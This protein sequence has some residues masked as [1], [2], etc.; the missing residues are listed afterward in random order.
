MHSSGNVIE[1]RGKW[2][3]RVQVAPGKREAFVMPWATERAEAAD[4]A[5][6]LL[7]VSA[8]IRATKNA[9]T[10][11]ILPKLLERAA[12]ATDAARL[13]DVRKVVDGLVAGSDRVE[14]R[15]TTIGHTFGDVAKAWTSGELAAKYPD[16]VKKKRSADDDAQRL[17]AHVLPTI[18]AVSMRS[19]TLDHA[20]RVMESLDAELAPATRRQVAQVMH[21][22]ASLAVYPLRLLAAH[23]LP[24]GWLPKIPKGAQ[25][26]QEMPKPSEVDQFVACKTEPIGVRL[27]AGFLA[28]EGL[29]HEEAEGLTW[30][31]VDLEDGIVRLDENKTNVP[32][33]WAL[34]ADVARALRFWFTARGSPKRSTRVF[35]D[36]KGDK[37]SLRADE[38]REALARARVTRAELHKGSKVTK[39][40]GLHALR[41]LFVSE[42]FA[43]GE[44][45]RWAMDRG[46]W[47]TSS[48]LS[49]YHRRART[50]MEAKVAPLGEL[51][52]LLGWSE[53]V[54]PRPK[55]MVPPGE[56][57]RS[58][59]RKGR[60]NNRSARVKRARAFL[61]SAAA[62]RVG[63]TPTGATSPENQSTSRALVELE[64]RETVPSADPSIDPVERA[65][66]AAI[67]EATKA[68]RWDV[69]GQLAKEL[70]ARRTA[71]A[72]GNVVSIDTA[73]RGAR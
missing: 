34:R 55:T 26:Q 24:K 57:G 15:R 71:R 21:R 44:S 52:V 7:A 30:A 23:P 27:L 28:R 18:G 54:V 37:L 60:S 46:G 72:A 64:E 73:K 53:T 39:P 9:D 5:S 66:S 42:G 12:I 29:R 2:Y 31:D 4:R 3:A 49:R 36:D 11:S 40:T 69:V 16:H 32:R 58:S 67:V 33:S 62:R 68:A 1:R 14:R 45:E 47:T 63:S 41:G 48:M 38:Y 8:E 20:E 17:K 59:R 70:E 25:H 13:A 65:L 50:F 6:F 61:K 19:F 56:G 35:V 22:V 51:D 10:L 43:R